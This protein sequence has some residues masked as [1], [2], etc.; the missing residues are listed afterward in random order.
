MWELKT[1]TLEEISEASNSLHLTVKVSQ[2]AITV[3]TKVRG[4]MV[5]QILG[6]HNIAT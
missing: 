3:G 1:A 6:N 2:C 5:V 4:M